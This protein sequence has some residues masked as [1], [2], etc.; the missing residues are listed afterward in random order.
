MVTRY[1]FYGHTI[2]KT[3]KRLPRPSIVVVLVPSSEAVLVGTH[4]KVVLQDRA[5]GVYDS[6]SIGM[7]KTPKISTLRCYLLGLNEL[8]LFYPKQGR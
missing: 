7:T 8:T 3:T 5:V 1:T 6:C 2:S 4:R